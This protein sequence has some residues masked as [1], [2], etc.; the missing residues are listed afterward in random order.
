MSLSSSSA[1][2]TG[3]RRRDERL[4]RA[5]FFRRFRPRGAAGRL[6]CP[7]SAQ[8]AAI[9]STG[10]RR[11]EAWRGAAGRRFVEPSAPTSSTSRSTSRPRMPAPC[12]L[13][14]RRR[15]RRGTSLPRPL[16]TSS[17][18]KNESCGKCVPCRVGDRR[19]S[20]P[21]R[22]LEAGGGPADVDERILSSRR[23]PPSLIC[24]LGQVAS[25]GAGVCGSLPRS[26][27]VCSH[28]TE[29]IVRQDNSSARASNEYR[30]VARGR[31]RRRG[32]DH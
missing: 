32:H 22:S 21:E 7:A 19:P 31:G 17:F 9:S 10:R 2:P 27:S 13:R 4:R 28:D 3:G 23:R 30:R 5:K 6:L 1:V 8:R 11:P 26:R 20:D 16:L 12:W 25:A 14:R 24:G 15:R 18:F 29:R